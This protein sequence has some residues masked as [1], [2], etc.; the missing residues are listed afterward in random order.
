MQ[1]TV[2]LFRSDYKNVCNE[3]SNS[4]RKRVSNKELSTNVK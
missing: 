3:Y 4:M 2:W 1:T